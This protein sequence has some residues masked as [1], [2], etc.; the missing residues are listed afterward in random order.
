M[1]FA[2]HG[3]L[4]NYCQL[5]SQDRSIRPEALPVD[6]S[7]FPESTVF[8]ETAVMSGAGGQLV[9]EPGQDEDAG[10]SAVPIPGQPSVLTPQQLLPYVE[11]AVAALQYAHDHGIIHL[12]VKPANLLLDSENRIMLADFGASTFLEGSTHASLHAFGGTPVY[13]PPKQ[14]L[15]HPPPP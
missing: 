11:G 6:A 4:Q 8:T 2:A 5:T 15:D 14:C 3:S 7:V 12:D 9:V 13:T 1:K 10:T